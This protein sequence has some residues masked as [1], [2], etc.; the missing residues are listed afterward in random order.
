MSN[1][2]LPLFLT[3]LSIAAFLL[4]WIL[5]RFT[6]PEAAQGVSKK[7]YF[8]EQGPTLTMI[9]GAAWALLWLAF[10]IGFKKKIS[11]GLVFVLHLIGTLFSLRFMIP[12]TENFNILFMAALPTLAAMLLLLKLR[13]QDTLLSL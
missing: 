11:Y 5:M 10:L 2:K 1:L 6:K 3:R 8:I 7:Y 13:D 12:G 9:V 4:P